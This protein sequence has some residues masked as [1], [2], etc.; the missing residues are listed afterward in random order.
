[1]A[2]HVGVIDVGKSNAK[3]A[4]VDLDGMREIDVLT[5]PNRVV[6]D[7]PYPHYDV[8]GLWA[9]MLDGLARLHREHRIDALTAT[10]HGASAV[11]LDADGGLAVPVLDYEHEGP[12][13]LTDAYDAVRPDFA[14]TG[15]PRL[16]MGMNLGAQ[17]FWQLETQTALRA[18]LAHVLTYPQ[19]WVWRL[20]GVVA[21]EMTSLG[22]HTDLWNPGARR[23]SS[24]V[25]RLGIGGRMAAV[26]KAAD[27]VGTI[28]PDIAARTGL[29]PAT[30]VCCGIHDSNASLYPHLVRRQAPFTV[31]STGTWVIAMAIGGR[32]VV[33]DPARD[34]LI[35]VNAFGD[36]VP[37]ARFM[38]GREFEMVCGSGAASASEDDVA[39]V[40]GRAV[41]LLP[42]VEP[43]SGPFQGRRAAWSEDVAGLGAG[44]RFAAASFYLAMM[45]A[46]CLG[47]IGAEGPVVTE[48][49]F[50]RNRL[51]LGMLATA[52]D[53]PVAGAGASATGTSIGAA[54]LTRQP[55]TV[56]AAQETGRIMPEPRFAYYA[57]RWREAVVSSG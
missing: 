5:L 48:G 45:T 47:M 25:D 21:N 44:E 50:A 22:C 3:V 6:R 52:L 29:D 7:G 18:R 12:D 55:P 51:Y 26:R 41:L 56:P 28:L 31:V 38:G 43:S 42:S 20:T 32:Q 24:L 46:T 15:S 34:T 8:D 1:M 35:N 19:Y 14:E 9:F 57:R 53:R 33:L 16:P 49:P 39:A 37:S 40:L 36:P 27:R 23:F 13:A 30:P 11:L 54:L 4:L 10:T 2:W 17:I